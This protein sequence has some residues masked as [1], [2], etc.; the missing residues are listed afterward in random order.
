MENKL[1]RIKINA[2]KL[3]IKKNDLRL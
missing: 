3:F 2:Q 1:N